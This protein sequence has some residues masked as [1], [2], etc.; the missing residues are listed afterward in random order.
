M[1]RRR[2]KHRS[3]VRARQRRLLQARVDE[4]HFTGAGHLVAHRRDQLFAGST[5]TTRNPRAS[6]L[7]VN[8]PVPQPISS[9]RAPA[10]SPA[11]SQAR[12]V[13]ASG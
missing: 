5:A 7:R 11:T 13:S 2:R 10:A 12:S 8:C 3:A 1:D 6:K 4:L 9:T